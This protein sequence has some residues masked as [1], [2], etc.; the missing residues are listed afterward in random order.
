MFRFFRFGPLMRPAQVID[1]TL[2]IRMFRLWRS[3]FEVRQKIRTHMRQGP[4]GRRISFYLLKRNKRNSGTSQ[5]EQ[6]LSPFRT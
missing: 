4:E 2:I 3:D 1:F 6:R 5:R